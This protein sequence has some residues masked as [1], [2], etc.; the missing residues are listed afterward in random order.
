MGKTPLEV[1]CETLG[2]PVT[3]TK[4]DDKAVL[5]IAVNMVVREAVWR[6]ESAGKHRLS[7]LL[8][9]L[10][11]AYDFGS[12]RRIW[13]ASG[14]VLA[15]LSHESPAR[16]VVMAVYVGS[17]VF[18]PDEHRPLPA[19][20]PGDA[21]LRLAVA[22]LRSRSGVVDYAREVFAGLDAFAEVLPGRLLVLDSEARWVLVNAP[23]GARAIDATLWRRGVPSIDGRA[24]IPLKN[25]VDG[26]RRPARIRAAPLEE[27]E[28]FRAERRADGWVGLAPV[29]A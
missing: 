1:I 28:E 2:C 8:S 14:S 11:P 12:A 20:P 17:Y 4:L 13:E 19:V 24:T 21:F 29:K 26:V 9:D 27:Q 5:S 25:I 7:H 23:H 10:G 18:G 3:P 6:L 15:V 22:A 16:D